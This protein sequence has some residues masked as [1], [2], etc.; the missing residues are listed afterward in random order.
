MW[1]DIDPFILQ[2]VLVVAYIFPMFLLNEDGEHVTFL[3]LSLLFCI[4]KLNIM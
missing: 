3:N 2:G 1:V 4:T